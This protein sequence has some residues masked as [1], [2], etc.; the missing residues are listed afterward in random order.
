MHQ[1]KFTVPDSRVYGGSK[2]SL[3]Q[4]TVHRERAFEE[5]L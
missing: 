5:V 2:S 1:L 3:V 4:T